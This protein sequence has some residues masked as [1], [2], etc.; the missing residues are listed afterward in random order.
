MA[1]ALT[2]I[3]MCLLVYV[4]FIFLYVLFCFLLHRCVPCLCYLF[5]FLS[6]AYLRVD[7]GVG[8]DGNKYVL[9]CLS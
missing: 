3:S 7:D 6:L 5:F 2:G 9:F 1:S 8:T 4:L